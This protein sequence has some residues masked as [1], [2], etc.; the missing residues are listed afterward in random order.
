M[1]KIY[2]L[3]SFILL[4]LGVW[5]QHTPDVNR[6]AT[7]NRVMDMV[8]I[9]YGSTSTRLKWDEDAWAQYVVHTFRNGETK[10]LFP[11]FSLNEL[12]MNKK[13]FVHTTKQQPATQ[14][15]WSKTIDLLFVDGRRLEALD[16]TIAH[17]INELGTPPFR[18]KI[19]MS[20]PIPIKGQTNWGKV[21][22]KTLNFNRDVDRIIAIKWFID[23]FMSR[24]KK[25]HY[26]NFDLEGFA[27][28]EE[29][30]EQTSGLAVQISNYLH[31]LGY[32]HYWKPYLKAKGSSYWDE[33]GF[34]YAYLQMGAYC[35]KE[36]YTFERVEQALAKA[37]RRGM[38]LVFEF[39]MKLFS[40]PDKFLPRINQCIDRLEQDKIY[41]NV[42]MSYY[43]GAAAIFAINKGQYRQYSVSSTN[44]NKFRI[45]LDRIAQHI[46]DRNSK[47]HNNPTSSS[48]TT[49]P[50]TSNTSDGDDWRNPD[51]WHF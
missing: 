8:G 12:G 15:E 38:G 27:W 13:S 26:E 10:W 25:H 35:I 18:H 47:T 37:K 22:G 11:G 1:K 7:N 48:T 4:S 33:Y 32:R 36:G 9:Y 34:D 50:S 19:I 43:D 41:E 5:A 51:Y 20:I 3:I 29:D 31:Q 30:M 28:T 6:Y 40:N 2:L 44:L 24:Y 23:E 21:N 45:M 16:K 42:S 17:Y 14:T 49:N 46:V 39:D